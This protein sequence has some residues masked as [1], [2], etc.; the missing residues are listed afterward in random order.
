M[1]TRISFKNFKGF[2][3]YEIDF[4]R[5][6]LLVG[7][8]NSGKTTV[9]HALQL[10]FWC[11]EQT[12][13]VSDDEATFRKTQVAQIGAL[14]YFSGRDIFYRRQTQRRQG[15][16]R[17]ELT[18]ETDATPPLRFA[19]YR[20]FS[21]NLM[22]DGSEQKV[23]RSQ[24]ERLLAMK[25]VYIAGAVGITVQEEYLRVV[26]QQRLIAEGRQNQ[27]L[28][29]LVYRLHQSGEWTAF[30]EFVAP[31][32]ALQ[33][34]DVPFDVDKDEWLTATYN[35][36]GCEF[37]LVSAGSGFLQTINLLC[38][39][40][41]NESRTALLDEPDSHMHDDLQR[42]VFGALNELSDRKKLQLIIATHSPT[43]VD[44]A[45]LDSVLLVDRRQSKPLVAQ[46]VETLVPLLADQGLSLPPNKVLET[47]RMR[48]AL[49]VEGLQADYDTFVAAMGEVHAP[50]FAA[51]TRGLTVF[52]TGGSSK[53]WPLDA[54][55]CFE[56]LLGAK[57]DYV[58][59]SDRDF[60]TDDEVAKREHDA[61][62]RGT[63]I[64]HLTR[65]HRESY[66]LDP[67]V[68][69][70]VLAG[71]WSKRHAEAVPTDLTEM[72]LREAIL[73]LAS[74]LEDDARTALVVE[75]ETSLRGD[76]QHRTD[77][78]R[79]LNEYFKIAYTEPLRKRAI[80]YKLLDAKAVLRR[81]RSQIA[82]AHS[83]SVSDADICKEF[84]ATELPADLVK[85]LDLILEMFS[86][87]SNVGGKHKNQSPKG[88]ALRPRGSKKAA[89]TRSSAPKRTNRT[90]NGDTRPK[91]HSRLSLAKAT[92]KKEATAK[93]KVTPKR[94]AESGGGAKKSKKPRGGDDLND[95]ELAVLQ[96]LAGATAAIHLNSVGAKAFSGF[97]EEKAY[98]WARNS[99]RK[100]LAMGLIERVSKGTYKATPAGKHLVSDA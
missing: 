32:F 22:V 91:A 25:P 58:Y 63:K 45:G 94:K 27:V 100:P 6:N 10:I 15:P 68:L 35:E 75:H 93:T 34:M 36:D 48:R 71:R 70:R 57:L 89:T 96:V 81:L 42:L 26:S 28:R 98:S 64:I 39:L 14:P 5:L 1:I 20:A 51:R 86:Q 49:F 13:D 33:G 17:I 88:T 99:V 12:V 50:G 54:I 85:L 61:G 8:N 87:T 23:T 24:Y 90:G 18:I 2:N 95:K 11:I 21:R 69:A 62:V 3:S 31:L 66:L 30:T 38:F 53:K 9:F 56:Q 46:S 97:P 16:V 41:L 40:F 7:G 76:N 77:G 67:A 47:L 59:L 19:I 82:Q 65:R 4:S 79:R 80:P 55:A 72:A 84:Q 83:I 44:A 52:E 74:E 73:R 60:L 29:N 78:T 37:D 92:P 43:M